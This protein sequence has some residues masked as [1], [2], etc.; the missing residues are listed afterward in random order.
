MLFTGLERPAAWL[1]DVVEGGNCRG[2]L[3]LFARA[4]VTA[5]TAGGE[6]AQEG[7]D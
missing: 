6:Q 4:R 1:G 5:A 2:L 7:R 3:L